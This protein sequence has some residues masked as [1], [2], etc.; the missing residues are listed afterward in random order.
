MV[1]R[2][3][4]HEQTSGHDDPCVPVVEKRITLHPESLDPDQLLPISQIPTSDGLH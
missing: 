3:F 2:S 1:V 4:S